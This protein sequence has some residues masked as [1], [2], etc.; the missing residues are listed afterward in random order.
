MA[1]KET[2]TVEH[3]QLSKFVGNWSTEGKIRATDTILKIKNSGT[4]GYNQ[5]PGEFFLLHKAN[6][7]IGKEKSETFEIIGFDK[8]I[9]KY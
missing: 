6:V 5:L 1:T 8:Q 7:L 3:N 9:G 4:V 2:S